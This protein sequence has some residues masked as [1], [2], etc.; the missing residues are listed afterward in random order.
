MLAALDLASRVAIGVG[1]LLATGWLAAYALEVVL[2]RRG[3]VWRLLP[4]RRPRRVTETWL[5]AVL[6]AAAIGAPIGGLG[7]CL[8]L[9]VW[10]GILAAV[11][12]AFWATWRVANDFRQMLALGEALLGGHLAE[13]DL[14]PLPDHPPKATGRRIVI[15]CDGTGNR[16]PDAHDPA[17]TNVWKIGQALVEDETQTLW[18][19][20]GVATGTSRPAKVAAS[21]ERWAGR[22]WLSPLATALGLAGR[23]RTAWEGLTGTGI[24]DNILDG[25]SEIARQ[26]RPGDRIYIFGFSRGAYT[27]RA[28][29]GAIRCC[30]LLKASNLRYAP[31]LMALYRARLGRGTGVPAQPE[32]VHRQVPI[33]MLG[34]FDTVA[35]LGAPLWGWWF[36]PRGIR[37]RAL[38]TSPM[39]NCRHVYHALAM[40][41]RRA[42]FFPTLFW[43]AGGTRSGWTETLEQVWFRGAHGDIGGGYPETGLSD[44]TLGWMLERAARHGL[45]L[46]P[47]ALIPLKPDPMARLHDETATRPSWS[48]LGTWPRWAMVLPGVAST[49]AG[50]VVHASVFERARLIREET[51]RHDLHDLQPGETVSFRAEA[52]RQWDRTGLVLRG[53]QDGPIFYRLRWR[54]GAWRDAACP[55]CGPAG[56]L[57]GE[58]EGDPRRRARWR[59]R[60]RDAPWMTLCATIAGPRRWPLRELPI[61]LALAYLFLRDPRLLLNQV[62]PL[63]SSLMQPGDSLLIRS[64]RPAGLL[65]LFANDLW[66][67]YANNSG[68]LELELTR[69]EADPASQEPLWL[70]PR[71]GRWQLLS[72]GARPRI[73]ADD[74]DVALDMPTASPAGTAGAG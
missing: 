29:A 44:I 26:Y 40:D 62:A 3:S 35:S 53:G 45:A 58:R 33:E 32:F 38:N 42:T 43:R 56:N 41:E 15:L 63:G 65:Y 20:P 69:L 17:A 70:L 12:A 11:L 48:W 24:G 2:R 64:E 73:P 16:Q 37:N 6:L 22:L 54:G 57:D 55:P 14:P 67:T 66:Q 28:I 8:G 34:V 13:A 19:D 39:P 49:G 74:P 5:V 50:I 31:A 61:K 59:R 47:G 51:G 60:V 1:L 72:G 23:L 7:G 71:S 9:P 4:E 27:A 36:N 21:L 18:Y 25:Y 30:G 10:L 68:E 46:R 52:Q